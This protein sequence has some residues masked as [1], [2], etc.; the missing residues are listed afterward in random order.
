MSNLGP[1]DASLFDA[2]PAAIYLADAQGVIR[3]C[4]PAAVEMWGGAP[5]AGALWCGFPRCFDTDLQVLPADRT[6]MAETVRTGVPVRGV[7]A[8]G[9]RFDGKRIRFLSSP[10]VFRDA[11][12]LVAG[13]INLLLDVSDRTRA[14][15]DSQRLAA[16]VASSDDAIVSKTLEGRITSWNRGAAHI[17][18]YDESEMVG[19]P[20]TKII[21]PELHAEEEEVLRRLRH[22][23]R[24]DHFETKRVTK[25]GRL[26]DVSLTVS[27][28]RDKSGKIVGASKVARDITA[29]RQAEKTQA[30]L[31]GELSHR[32]KNTLATVQ[33]IATQSLRRSSDPRE[34]VTSFSGRIQALAR[35]H[36]LL[37]ETRWEGMSLVALVREQVLLETTDNRIVWSG[38]DVTLTP[39]PGLHLALVLHE[40]GTN[41]RKH[42]ALSVPHGRLTINWRVVETTSGREVRLQWVE[43]GGPRPVAPAS[44]GF[45]TTLIEGGLTASGGAAVIEYGDRGVTCELTLPLSLPRP[46]V[47]PAA[48]LD[49]PSSR[50]EA[51]GDP[52]PGKRILVVED[53]PLI[54]M[55][56][57]STLTEAGCVI[58]GPTGNLEE[59]IELAGTGC[60]GALL[61]ANLGGA[62][63][64]K[65]AAALTGR[66]IPFA[67]VSGYGVDALPASFRGTTLL[68]KPFTARQLVET[69]RNLL[70]D[71]PPSAAGHRLASVT[72]PAS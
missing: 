29:R 39:Q 65:L 2:L 66:A 43:E 9:E 35:S 28:L 6:P 64:D 50:N 12:G 19:E 52:L 25:D 27:P 8:I 33:A 68:A 10:N 23:E 44:R 3:Y 14:E 34:F 63:V 53:E 58:V 32:V 15:A 16:I 26:I 59:A 31:I 36:D 5:R 47:L 48:N 41:A 1:A 22:G 49:S 54:A 51:P 67:F 45:G 11:Q 7:E 69:V 18:G 37:S 17:F 30:L 70:R 57:V 4:N 62:P 24:I 61:D 21:P 72:S 60:D 71:H 40:L 46:R 13:A 38:P 20:I 56:I 42:G 55:D